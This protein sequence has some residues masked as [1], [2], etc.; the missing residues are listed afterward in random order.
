MKK[1]ALLI[2]LGFV[3]VVVAGC[4]VSNPRVAPPPAKVEVVSAKPGPNHVWI[5]GYWKWSRNAY[6]W[7]PGHWVKAKPGKTWVPGHWDKRGPHWV[8]IPGHWK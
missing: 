7:V 6:V 3:S 2:L 5:A 8:W 4:V 1:T